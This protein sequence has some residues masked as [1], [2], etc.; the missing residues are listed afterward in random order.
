MARHQF[1]PGKFDLKELEKYGPRLEI[2]VGLPIVPTSKTSSV[3]FA[4]QQ[5]KLSRMPALVDTGASRTV[6]TPEAISRLGLPLVDQVILSRAG[7][8]DKVGAYAASIHFPRYH[9]ATIEGIQVLC[10]ELPHQ[11]VQCLIGRDI[12]SR[13]LFTYHGK[14]GWWSIEEEDRKA[15][16]EPPE[17]LWS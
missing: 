15:W 6:L 4:P 17:G 10:C 3:H 11:P 13:W 16:V 5:Q 8:E 14:A 1:P 2:E 7:G 9:F 12:I